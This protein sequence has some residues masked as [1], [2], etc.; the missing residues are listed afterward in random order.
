TTPHG[1]GATN[2]ARRMAPTMTSIHRSVA[3]LASWTRNRIVSP[4]AARPDRV[5]RRR[6]GTRATLLG[7]AARRLAR[8]AQGG[9][10][11]GPPDPHGAPLA[12][13]ARAGPRSGR[14]PL[15]ALLPRPRPRAGDR[16]PRRAGR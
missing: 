3:T 8:G 13:A 7:D 11:A 10:R 16:A 15:T 12:R 6:P 14:P 2:R 1:A 4:H 9:R 5:P